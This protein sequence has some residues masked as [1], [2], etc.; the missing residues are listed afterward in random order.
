MVMESEHPL[1][2]VA[3]SWAVAVPESKTCTTKIFTAAIFRKAVS[4]NI[5]SGNQERMQATDA[6]C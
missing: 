3:H 1:K 5:L 4:V 2:A 6:H